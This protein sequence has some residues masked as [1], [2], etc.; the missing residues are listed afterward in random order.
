MFH[1]H[2]GTNASTRGEC[3]LDFH[4]AGVGDGHQI[5]EDHIGD[6]LV[7]GAMVA[8]L[9]EIQFEG[10]ELVADLVSNIGDREGAEVW[11]PGFRAYRREFRGDG[12]DHKIAVREWVV[13]GFEDIAGRVGHGNGFAYASFGGCH[14]ER[15][16]A[17]ILVRFRGTQW[18]SEGGSG[19]IPGEWRRLSGI[20]G[21]KRSFR[22]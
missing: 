13:E 19:G 6:A 9:L 4:P 2:G 3:G 20:C 12:L 7:K 14:R 17:G 5:V 8:V 18:G 21:G 11:M 1:N 10:F 15:R 16:S 22:E